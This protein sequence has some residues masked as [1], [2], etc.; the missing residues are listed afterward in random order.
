MSLT[1]DKPHVNKSTSVNNSIN[2][3][4]LQHGVCESDPTAAVMSSLLSSLFQGFCARTEHTAGLLELARMHLLNGK[5][6][7]ALRHIM[8]SPGYSGKKNINPIHQR[9]STELMNHRASV[10]LPTREDKC[11]QFDPVTQLFMVLA[12]QLS[13]HSSSC[14]GVAG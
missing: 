11:P 5:A 1:E 4:F 13:Y 10:L 9:P 8:Q 2:K 6:Q 12:G 14:N 7:A 3:P